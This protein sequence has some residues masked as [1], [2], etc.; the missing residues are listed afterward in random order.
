MGEYELGPDDEMLIQEAIQNF[1]P[2]YLPLAKD[3][4]VS[5][6]SEARQTTFL[7]DLTDLFRGHTGLY[8][9]QR[10]PNAEGYRQI[11]Q[12]IIDELHTRGLLAGT[13]K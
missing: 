3:F 1:G 5:A 10:H 11:A 12:A 2:D 6:G 7:V 13:R 8:R 9:D 4:F